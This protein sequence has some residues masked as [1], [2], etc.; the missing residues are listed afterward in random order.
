M[1]DSSV[2][3]LLY[4]V[5]SLKLL[6]FGA[7]LFAARVYTSLRDQILSHIELDAQDV[8]CSSLE[9]FGND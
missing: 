9:R 8:S 2:S 6:G 7:R 3:S 5:I 1:F 4:G